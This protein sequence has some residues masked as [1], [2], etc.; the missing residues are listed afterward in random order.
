MVG[1]HT[2]KRQGIEPIAKDDGSVDIKVT[3]LLQDLIVD[4]S[5]E[6]AF[7]L[8]WL[9]TLSGAESKTLQQRLIQQNRKVLVS[10]LLG[11]SKS[12]TAFVFVATVLF[13]MLLC[14]ELY[15]L[16]LSLDFVCVTLR[17]LADGKPS[18]ALVVRKVWMELQDAATAAFRE[19]SSNDL[20]ILPVLQHWC[21]SLSTIGSLE[22]DLKVLCDSS[23]LANSTCLSAL[24]FHVLVL[25]YLRGLEEGGVSIPDMPVWGEVL[26]E[27]LRSV[28]YIIRT[29]ADALSADQPGSGRVLQQIAEHAFRV[30]QSPLAPKDAV[31]GGAGVFLLSLACMHANSSSSS[32]GGSAVVRRVV[33]E[34]LD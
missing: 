6:I 24:R 21:A 18:L 29:N 13:R 23:P 14:P 27:G 15:P 7:V 10:Y 22:R 28:S 2:R 16:Q 31:A 19:A 11:S 3:Y 32:G 12:A 9:D 30:L 34:V 25:E 26:S 4:E 1:K 17:G 33:L 8:K 5:E 20:P